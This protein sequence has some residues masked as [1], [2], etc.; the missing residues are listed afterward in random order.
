M[1]KLLDRDLFAAPKLGRLLVNW[2]RDHIRVAYEVSNKVSLELFSSFL[3]WF[4]VGLSVSFPAGLYLANLNVEEVEGL[5]GLTGGVAIYFQTGTTESEIVGMQDW[6]AQNPELELKEVRSS[7]KAFEDL[8]STISD[9]TKEPSLMDGIDHTVLPVTM[10]VELPA[11]YDKHRLIALRAEIEELP[12]VDSVAMQY[13]WLERLTA[14]QSLFENLWILSAL[15]FGLASVL[16][17]SISISFAIQSQLEELKVFQFLGATKRQ[18]R[19]PFIY[20]GAI[21]GIG[22]GLMALFIL[23]L[24]LSV[25]EPSVSF[26]YLSYGREGFIAGFDLYFSLILI[27]CCV[28]LGIIGARLAASRELDNLD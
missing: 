11:G 5:V 21:F 7:E 3:T 20:L 15:L 25:I 23:A 17:T 28:A 13:E 24:V 19:R 26:L 10:L 27:S 14:F 16:V 1:K 9:Q 6:V 18:V 4:I 2:L 22:G 12:R 8:M